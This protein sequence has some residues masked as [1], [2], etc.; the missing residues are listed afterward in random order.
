MSA[1]RKPGAQRSNTP[2]DLAKAVSALK[3]RGFQVARARL[4]ADGE[5]VIDLAPAAGE[6]ADPFDLVD[7]RR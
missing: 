1:Q 6:T 3:E 7:M 5:I 2:A 4:T